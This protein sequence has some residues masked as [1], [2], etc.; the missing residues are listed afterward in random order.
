MCNFSPGFTP[1]FVLHVFR[2]FQL[3]VGFL[4]HVS[5]TGLGA[6]L[7]LN[8]LP[9]SSH[10]RRTGFTSRRHSLLLS[11]AWTARGLVPLHNRRLHG[12]L[13]LA[14]FCTND[15]CCASHITA[16][17]S[18]CSSRVSA[19]DSMSTSRVSLAQRLCPMTSRQPLFTTCCSSWSL[20]FPALG[21]HPTH[22]YCPRYLAACST[23]L[24]CYIWL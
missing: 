13:S 7:S 10:L 11:V 22:P 15:R 20:T 4:M 3:Q 5:S 2:E 14:V 6:R 16:C 8:R 19:Y 18:N 9:P 21:S 24:P 23:S 12:L 1:S 17:W